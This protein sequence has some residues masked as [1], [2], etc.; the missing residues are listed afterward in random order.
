M[1]RLS[2]YRALA[3]VLTLVTVLLGI[4]ESVDAGWFCRGRGR[5]ICRPRRV[6]CEPCPPVCAEPLNCNGYVCPVEK[7]AEFLGP[8]NTPMYCTYR[9]RQCGTSNYFNLDAACN[10]INQ[11]ENGNCNSYCYLFSTGVGITPMPPSYSHRTPRAYSRTFAARGQGRQYY[12]GMN[13]ADGWHVDT[14]P[15][16]Y[17]FMPGNRR[18][19]LHWI[20]KTDSGGNEIDG[21]GIGVHVDRNQF[22][23][24]IQGSHVYG[25]LWQVDRNR[26]RYE[27]YLRLR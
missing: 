12:Y 1:V 8:A 16:I 14:D 2:R 4:A 11:C 5:R 24:E 26:H 3:I 21:F 20:Y 27:V 17:K 13:L 18:V 6:R 9:A 22:D 19:Q 10:G 7:I 25:L 23:H 15:N